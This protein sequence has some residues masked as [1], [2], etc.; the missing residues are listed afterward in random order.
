MVDYYEL[1]GFHCDSVENRTLAAPVTATARA[2]RNARAAVRIARD[3]VKGQRT[4]R[5][6]ERVIP[7]AIR[8]AP[9]P[10]TTI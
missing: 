9:K 1:A 10:Y 3:V 7:V 5:E 8:R 6:G 2:A 4:R